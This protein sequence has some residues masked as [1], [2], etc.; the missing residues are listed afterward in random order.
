MR[1]APAGGVADQL[2]RVAKRSDHRVLQVH[3][4]QCRRG[5]GLADRS[6]EW[7]GVRAEEMQRR[8]AD[9]VQRLGAGHRDVELDADEGLVVPAQQDVHVKCAV[10]VHGKTISASNETPRRLRSSQ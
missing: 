8:C 3:G 1:V 2:A 9:D 10:N 7:D 6:V 4:R 5:L